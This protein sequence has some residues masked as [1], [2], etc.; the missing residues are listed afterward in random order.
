M[1]ALN[2]CPI[3]GAVSLIARTHP[4]GTQGMEIRAAPLIITHS[5]LISK[6]WSTYHCNLRFCCPSYLASKS[7]STSAGGYKNNYVKDSW[8]LCAPH[9]SN[10]EAVT[11]LINPDHQG[12]NWHFY[13]HE[14]KK[15]YA[16]NGGNTWASHRT[17]L[18]C[19]ENKWENAT[20]QFRQD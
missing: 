14:D 11:V 20:A 1:S 8:T 2:Q 16:W 7:R 5:D 13:Y 6:T 15:K 17:T 18:P 4:P 3:Y 19:H 12:G 10:S 9:G